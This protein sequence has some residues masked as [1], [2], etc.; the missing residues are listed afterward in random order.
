MRFAVRMS[1]LA[2]FVETR[3]AGVVQC[4]TRPE[5]AVVLIN[6]VSRHPVVVG[7]ASFRSHAQ[8]VEDLARASVV[9]L[10]PLAEAL[11]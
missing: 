9:K 7:D 11:C 3:G 4:G 6:L 5:D 1:K 8:F 10:V 2:A